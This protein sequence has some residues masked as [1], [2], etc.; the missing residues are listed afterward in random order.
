MTY[1]P[2]KAT[3]VK[4]T[5]TIK[6]GDL[7]RTVTL[8]DKNKISEGKIILWLDDLSRHIVPEDSMV[9]VLVDD[10]HGYGKATEDKSIKVTTTGA[11]INKKNCTITFEFSQVDFAAIIENGLTPISDV[12]ISKHK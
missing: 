4:R 5:D 7:L 9:N 8:V 6:I 1:I 10:A 12:A 2:T 11:I 3:K